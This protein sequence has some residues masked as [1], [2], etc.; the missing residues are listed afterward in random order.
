MIDSPSKRLD[1]KVRKHEILLVA[2]RMAETDGLATLRRDE[3]A[4]TADIANG[5]VTR[6]FN[7]MGQLRRAVVRYAVHHEN[8]PILAQALAI[9]D[10]EALKAPEDLKKKAV[11]SLNA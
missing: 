6:Y 1:P 7:T 4:K 11:A 10:P 2:V 3:I 8:L 9:R 5:L